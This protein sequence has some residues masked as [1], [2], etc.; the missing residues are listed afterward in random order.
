MCCGNTAHQ[1]V[2]EE[3]LLRTH[4]LNVRLNSRGAAQEMELSGVIEVS[5]SGRVFPEQSVEQPNRDG[6]PKPGCA[7]ARCF[8]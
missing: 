1:D 7:T 6:P 5:L 8:D 4:T 2:H 3:G